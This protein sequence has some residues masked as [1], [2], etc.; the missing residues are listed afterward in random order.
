M[1]DKFEDVDHIID[2]IFTSNVSD[3]IKREEA[4]KQN[5]SI[6]LWNIIC[7]KIFEANFLT[8]KTVFNV[9]HYLLDLQATSSQLSSISCLLL[10]SVNINRLPLICT[11]TLNRF[12]CFPLFL[13]PSIYHINSKSVSDCK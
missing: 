5:Y 2:S 11:Y 3:K 4:K 1:L 8:I 13:F 6:N 10:L 9:I 7:V 12:F